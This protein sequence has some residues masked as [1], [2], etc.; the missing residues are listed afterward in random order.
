MPKSTCSVSSRWTSLLTSTLS[1]ISASIS[2]WCV[3]LVLVHTYT[4]CSC[5]V[6]KLLAALNLHAI[7]DLS[8]FAKIDAA[9]SAYLAALAK[10]NA[11]VVV[12]IGKG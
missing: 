11:D 8:I 9:L 6:Q 5:R 7:L 2:S 1:S 10:I 12:K 3:L 4:L